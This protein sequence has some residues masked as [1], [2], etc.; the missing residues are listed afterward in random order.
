MIAIDLGEED[1]AFGEELVQKF[2]NDISI[3]DGRAIDG[4]TLSF[5]TLFISAA[6][7]TIPEVRKIVVEIIKA[8]RHKAVTLKGIKFQGY[9]DDEVK[10]ILAELQK[11]NDKL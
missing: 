10:N 3:I 9:S 6:G 5:I 1:R 8:K 4:T 2:S 7:V 11:A